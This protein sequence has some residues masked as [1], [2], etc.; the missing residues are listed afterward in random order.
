MLLPILPNLFF[1]FCLRFGINLKTDILYNPQGQ[2]IVE[3]THQTL[4]TQLLKQKGGIEYATPVNRFNHTLFVLN[5]LNV[6]KQG[7]SAA[8]R[9]WGPSKQIH[10]LV[11][12]KDPL[13][14]Q[15]MGP[16]PV[17]MWGRGFLCIF[18]RDADSPSWI[19]KKIGET[20]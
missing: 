1:S 2:G 19:P 17:L 15:W 4:K 3:H 7:Q 11:M 16:N 12:W 6:D 10:P 9:F 8:E 5:F 20:S 18:P 13:T 14:N